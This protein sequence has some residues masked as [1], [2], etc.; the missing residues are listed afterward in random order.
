MSAIVTV[1]VSGRWRAGASLMMLLMTSSR[2][3][4]HWC[5]EAPS[6]VATWLWQPG[7]GVTVITPD[8]HPYSVCLLRRGMG[9][10][11]LRQH[12]NK[13]AERQR[14]TYT[15]RAFDVG[16]E[17][18]KPKTIC[19]FPSQS[20]CGQLSLEDRRCGNRQSRDQEDP[21]LSE[22]TTRSGKF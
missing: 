11:G 18:R 20:T 10:P 2:E 4:C 7:G 12:A 9:V 13:Q 21:F 1:R 16:M 17:S 8:S 3:W 5:G 15:C 22:Q 6:T 19:V 14:K